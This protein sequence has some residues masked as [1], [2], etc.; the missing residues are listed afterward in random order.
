MNWFLYILLIYTWVVGC[1]I[2][3]DWLAQAAD[4]EKFYEDSTMR[5]ITFLAILFWPV[6][7]PLAIYKT[8][9]KSK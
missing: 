1:Y 4:E 6:I 9:E 8:R 7:V 2:T 5:I 3:Q